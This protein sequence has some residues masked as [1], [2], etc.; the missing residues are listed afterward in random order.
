MS[1]AAVRSSRAARVPS[2]EEKKTGWGLWAVVAAGIVL[3]A[4]A[5]AWFLGWIS[6]GTDPRVVEIRGLQ[7]EARKQFAESG[8]PRTVADATAA[9]T[10][11]NTIRAKTEALP[12]RLRTQVEQQ[13]RGV[14]RT[15]M[16]A[17]I[18]SYF[19]TPPEKRQAELD[20]QIDQEEMMRKAFETASAV[21]GAMGMGQNA[22]AGQGAS[23]QASTQPQ[24][25]PAGGGPPRSGSEEDRNRWRKSMIDST[26]PEQRAKYVEYRRAMDERRQQRGLPSGWGR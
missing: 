22:Q 11:M 10:A 7:E 21:A 14:F 20:R 8:G 16:R 23:G 18:D 1:T 25:P 2:R 6:F 19:S 13:G 9:V 24:G 15:A 12:P 17:R 26:T 3:L 4:L 5:V